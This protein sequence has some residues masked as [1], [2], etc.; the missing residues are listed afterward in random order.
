MRTIQV[1]P[2]EQIKYVKTISF[3]VEYFGKYYSGKIVYKRNLSETNKM[4]ET[5]RTDI[6]R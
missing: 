6:N 5:K 3:N 1:L 2:Q 4:D